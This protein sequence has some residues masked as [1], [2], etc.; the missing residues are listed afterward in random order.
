MIG[1]LAVGLTML[2][3]VSFLALLAVMGR[4]GGND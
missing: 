3:A 4:G 2:W 1:T